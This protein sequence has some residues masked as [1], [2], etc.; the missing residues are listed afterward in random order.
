M[1][2]GVIECDMKAWNTHLVVGKEKF[3][4]KLDGGNASDAN[5]HRDVDSAGA[6]GK[7]PGE[8][9]CQ[10]FRSDGTEVR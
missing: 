6:T 5:V 9:Y 7:Y 2:K 3:K 10:K 1:N 8:Y 4:M